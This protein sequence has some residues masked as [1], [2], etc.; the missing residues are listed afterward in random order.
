MKTDG[1]RIKGFNM[2]KCSC[3][4]VILLGVLILIRC[5][6]SNMLCC[7]VFVFL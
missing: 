7:N 6:V 1:F 3:S 4:V 5:N 2:L